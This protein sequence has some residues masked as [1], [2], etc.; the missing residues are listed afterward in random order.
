MN[1]QKNNDIMYLASPLQVLSAIDYCQE[2][3]VRPI[4]IVNF[5]EMKRATNRNQIASLLEKLPAIQILEFKHFKNSIARDFYTFIFMLKLKKLPKANRFLIGDFRSKIACNLFLANR[6]NKRI[7]I[8]DGAATIAMQLEDIKHGFFAPALSKRQRLFQRAFDLLSGL[9]YADLR[10]PDIYSIFDGEDFLRAEQRNL[11]APT[12]R[13]KKN[14]IENCCFF[15]GSK[16]SESKLLGLEDEI[17]IANTIRSHYVKS[18]I[19]FYYIPHRDESKAKLAKLEALGITVK[20][21]NVPAE[22]YFQ[23]ATELPAH[24]SACWST[25]LYSVGKS[26]ELTSVTSFDI[27]DKVLKPQINQRAQTVYD[28]YEQCGI[29]RIKV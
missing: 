15:F 25:V 28:F 12:T 19:D 5:G 17:H 24:I 21:L 6:A 4:V 16:Y 10:C 1:N 11:R 2:Y 23:E 22:V 26:Y 14:L 7:Y 13:I 27:L 3:K 9:N 8:D 20:N 29:K 18:N